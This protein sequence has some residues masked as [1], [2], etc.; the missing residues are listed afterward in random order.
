MQAMWTDSTRERA[1]A[2]ARVPHPYAYWMLK[3]GSEIKL[4]TLGRSCLGAFWEMTWVC[5]DLSVPLIHQHPLAHRGTYDLRSAVAFVPTVSLCP[6]VPL[7]LFLTFYFPRL[8]AGPR[9]A[10]L[11]S[12]AQASTLKKMQSCRPKRLREAMHTEASMWVSF[13]AT[14]TLARAAHILP[15][16][17]GIDTCVCAC[18]CVWSHL[19]KSRTASWCPRALWECNKLSVDLSFTLQFKVALKT[20][21]PTKL[22]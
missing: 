8:P 7:H 3:H 9:V 19:T 14:I 22:K 10:S 2:A 13:I 1:G 21:A 4:W 20:A 11:A 17:C 12:M 18:V 5:V 15:A 16:G 6:S